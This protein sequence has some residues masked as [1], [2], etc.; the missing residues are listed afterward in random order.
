MM[1]Y[2]LQ[3]KIR[4]KMEYDLNSN[5][6]LAGMPK[7]SAVQVVLTREFV[8]VLD[9]SMSALYIHLV[10]HTRRET[11]HCIPCVM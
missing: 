9:C 11:T 10:N 3:D 7:G 2:L 4:L 5:V 6:S 8:S 1:L